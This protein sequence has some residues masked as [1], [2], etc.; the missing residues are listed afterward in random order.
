MCT[1]LL[2]ILQTWPFLCGY[3]GKMAQEP[4]QG[5]SYGRTDYVPS[6]HDKHQFGFKL[7]EHS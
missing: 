7:R 5:T 6:A 2:T 4:P 1:M 3:L